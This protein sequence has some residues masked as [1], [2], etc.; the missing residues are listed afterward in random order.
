MEIEFE[1][2]NSGDDIRD[3]DAECLLC[4]GFESHIR[5]GEKWAQ[6]VRRYR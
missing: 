6:C 3:G 4:T 2:D 1:N 5:H